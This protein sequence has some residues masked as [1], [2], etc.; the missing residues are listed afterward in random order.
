MPAKPTRLDAGLFGG[1]DELV[2]LCLPDWFRNA[3]LSLTERMLWSRVWLND[4]WTDYQLT[5]QDKTRIEYGIFKLTQDDCGQLDMETI[6]EILDRLEELENMNINVNC[7]CGCGGC[8]GQNQ[9]ALE[10]G[11]TIDDLC[12]QVELPET[13]PPQTAI[14][15]KCDLANYLIVQVRTTL[16]N[17]WSRSQ[18][19]PEFR[20]WWLNLFSFMPSIYIV[21]QS[22]SSYVAVS[23]WLSGR[24]VDWITSNFDPLFNE[25]VCALYSS[26]NPLAAQTALSTVMDKLP[27]PLSDSAKAI[28]QRLPYGALFASDIVSPPGFSGRECCGGVPDAQGV[29]PL[30]EPPVGYFWGTLVEGEF[31]FVVNN[32]SGVADY[33]ELSA[34]FRMSPLTTQ[35]FHEVTVSVDVSDIIERLAA[36][37]AHGIFVQFVNPPAEQFNNNGIRFSGNTGGS[38]VAGNSFST[39]MYYDNLE[40][41]NETEYQDF[42]DNVAANTKYFYGNGP[43]DDVK[44]TFIMQ[45]YGTSGAQ[46]IRAAISYLLKE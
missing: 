29:G 26:N 4:D 36:S 18:S 13:A 12:P 44:A 21:G 30:P 10:D 9:P 35:T 41:A 22:Y 33:N 46:T 2:Y 5:D 24:A 42:I 20:D 23:Q 39:V 19:W 34:Q 1:S 6:Q 27:Y 14:G 32:G 31:E 40:Y 16:I 38:Y 28:A 43:M 45:S 37:T 15:E 25:M 3:L 17:Q 11:V 8:G 7:G